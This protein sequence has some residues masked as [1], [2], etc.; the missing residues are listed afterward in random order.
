MMNSGLKGHE[1]DKAKV[2]DL[3]RGHDDGKVQIEFLEGSSE[4]VIDRWNVK[5]SRLEVV[6]EKGEDI[7]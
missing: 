7:E 6:R 1:G 2:T 3:D 4:K 5:P